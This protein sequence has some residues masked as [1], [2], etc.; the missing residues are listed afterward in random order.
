VF[1]IY[2]A[3]LGRFAPL[4]FARANGRRAL[5]LRPPA[6]ALLEE[7][8]RIPC[9]T[10]LVIVTLA[11]VTF[12]GLSET[13]LW[14][15]AAEAIQRTARTASEPAIMAFGWLT[16][17]GVFALLYG[18]LAHAMAFA[19]RVTKGGTSPL[20]PEALE[21]RFVLTLLPIAI[22]YYLAHYLSFLLLAG[23]YAIPLL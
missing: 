20:S 17:L 10:G 14:R 23:Q 22:A 21:R 15:D 4:G 3:I 16:F 8:P 12:D 19:A 1:S 18:V 2:F 7:P 6:A 5:V 11:S 13:P 9:F